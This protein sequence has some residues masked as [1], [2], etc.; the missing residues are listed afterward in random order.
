MLIHEL[1]GFIEEIKGD[2][3]LNITL[4]DSNNDALIKYREVWDEIKDQIK[5]INNSLRG[6]YEKDYIRIK[7]DSDDNLPLNKIL[8]FHLVAIAIRNIFDKCIYDKYY[9]QIFLDG[10]LYE[11]DKT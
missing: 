5:K 6:E 9:P 3:C 2:K 10:C 1:D 4:T 8:K 7:S 11:N